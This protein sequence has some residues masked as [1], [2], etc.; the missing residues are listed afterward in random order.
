MMPPQCYR[1]VF[2]GEHLKPA[3][4]DGRR[5]VALAQVFADFPV[6]LFIAEKEHGVAH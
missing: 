3:V 1:N 4:A 2:T 6:A 5:S